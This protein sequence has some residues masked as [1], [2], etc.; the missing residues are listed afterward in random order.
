MLVTALRC[1]SKLVC[2][3]PVVLAAHAEGW[4]EVSA[5]IYYQRRFCIYMGMANAKN[6]AVWEKHEPIY[7][8]NSDI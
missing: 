1:S 2:A 3:N 5:L 8:L 4:E 6:S 7:A